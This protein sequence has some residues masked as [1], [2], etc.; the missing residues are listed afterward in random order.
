MGEWETFMG[1]EIMWVD[2][3]TEKLLIYILC[4]LDIA[5]YT[6]SVVRSSGTYC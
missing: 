2:L 1:I 5:V 3:E 4:D 6:S